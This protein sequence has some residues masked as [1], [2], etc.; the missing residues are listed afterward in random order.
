MVARNTEEKECD[1][2]GGKR[3]IGRDATP[4]HGDFVLYRAVAL[5]VEYNSP[6]GGL[7][8]R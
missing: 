2:A 8:H 1:A 7:A 6:G 3:A 5:Y 4:Q